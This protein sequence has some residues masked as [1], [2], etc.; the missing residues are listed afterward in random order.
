MI[1][2]TRGHDL[3]SLNTTATVVSSSSL[4]DDGAVTNHHTFVSSNSKVCSNASYPLFIFH[5]EMVTATTGIVKLTAQYAHDFKAVSHLDDL[6]SVRRR[7]P[8]N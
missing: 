2:L 8:Y 5:F 3:L 4:Q 1:K 6:A 7:R